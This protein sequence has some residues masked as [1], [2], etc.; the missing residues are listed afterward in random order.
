MNQLRALPWGALSQAGIPRV[1]VGVSHYT[2]GPAESLGEGMAWILLLG[3]YQ[4]EAK[5]RVCSMGVYTAGECS[6]RL[7]TQTSPSTATL[8]THI[9]PGSGPPFNTN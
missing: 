2:G 4:S 7:G 6:L 8:P 1:G 9:Q 3:V 5:I